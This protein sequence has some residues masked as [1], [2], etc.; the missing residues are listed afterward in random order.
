ML[1][2]N[3]QKNL[4]YQLK[5]NFISFFFYKK[6]VST[7]RFFQIFDQNS[8]LINFDANVKKLKGTIV[9]F[10]KKMTEMEFQLVKLP[11]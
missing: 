7:L 3:Y 4:F 5:S 1:Y 9:F 6:Q 2:Q 10:E 11:F 8:W